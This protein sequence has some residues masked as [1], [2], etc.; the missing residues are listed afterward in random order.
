MQ[1]KNTGLQKLL[2]CDLDGWEKSIQY[3]EGNSFI[4]SCSLCYSEKQKDIDYDFLY[5]FPSDSNFKETKY[6][7]RLDNLKEGVKIIQ[8]QYYK[9]IKYIN[10]II[11]SNFITSYKNVVVEQYCFIKNRNNFVIRCK[12]DDLLDDQK[13]NAIISNDAKEIGK[14]INFET[15][16]LFSGD[17]VKILIEMLL[18][19]VQYR[20]IVTRKSKLFNSLNQKIINE[21]LNLTTNSHYNKY[22][23]EGTENIPTII[24]E[25]GVLKKY[26]TSIYDQTTY[27]AP[28]SGFVF[29]NKD[30]IHFTSDSFQLQSTNSCNLSFANKISFIE[31]GRLL[32]FNMRNGNFKIQVL[33]AQLLINGRIQGR[34][35]PRV[36]ENNIYDLLG[37][38]L[39]IQDNSI[40]INMG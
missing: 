8:Y 20:N 25:H 5:E 2:I 28:L 22:D 38:D 31:Y 26:L 19:A 13:T 24:V 37:N 11:K 32:K 27:D 6:I 21:N 17:I 14:D 33:Q 35:T 29:H 18:S 9:E 34:Y 15:I 10:S 23:D 39:L 1:Y 12:P 4:K 30:D 7:E 36:F 3:D 16:L 40:M